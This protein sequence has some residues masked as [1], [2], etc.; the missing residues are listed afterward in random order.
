MLWRHIAAHKPRG[1]QMTGTVT[2]KFQLDM[3]GAILALNVD[4]SSGNINL[5]RIAL[6]TIRQS[7]AFPQPP[8]SLDPRQ[9]V[10][11]IP[12]EFH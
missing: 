3:A 10:F 11:V 4:R 5:D 2:V 9:L 1:V 8:V 6:R 12:I 7:G